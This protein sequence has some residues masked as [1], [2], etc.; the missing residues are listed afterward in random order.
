VRAIEKLDIAPIESRQHPFLS[1]CLPLQEN[2]AC[3]MSNNLE[4]HLVGGSLELACGLMMNTFQ[5]T[6]VQEYT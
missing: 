6:H 4:V 2:W 1:L 5:L 3:A